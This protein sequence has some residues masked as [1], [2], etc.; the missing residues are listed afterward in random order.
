MLRLTA[1][2]LGLALVLAYH[3]A[4][5]P[6]EKATQTQQTDVSGV[7]NVEVDLGGNTGNPVFTFKQKGEELTGKYKGQLGEADLKGK[8]TGNKIEF[9]FAVGDLGKAVYTGTIENDTMKGKAKYGDQL[10][11]TFTGK[12]GKKEEK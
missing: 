12:R 8:V 6:K 4:A 9:S 7:W 11:G 3:G 2:T 10:E 5:A 1:L